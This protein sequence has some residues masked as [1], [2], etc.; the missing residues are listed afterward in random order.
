MNCTELCIPLAIMSDL[1][2]YYNSYKLDKATHSSCHNMKN[3]DMQT[4]SVL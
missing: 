1:I 4:L 3:G 2:F